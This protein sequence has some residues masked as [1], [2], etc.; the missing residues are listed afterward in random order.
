MAVGDQDK[1]VGFG[2]RPRPLHNRYIQTGVCVRWGMVVACNRYN[3][4][5]LRF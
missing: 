3:F 5:P 1:T 4:K 2:Q